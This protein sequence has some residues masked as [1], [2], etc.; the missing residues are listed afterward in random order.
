MLMKG[1]GVPYL[2]PIDYCSFFYHWEVL[3]SYAIFLQDHHPSL[4]SSSS[5]RL[6]QIFWVRWGQNNKIWVRNSKQRCR[7]TIDQPIKKTTIQILYQGWRSTKKLA[8]SDNFL[9]RLQRRGRQLSV[10]LD[11]TKYV[12][13][14][15]SLGSPAEPRPGHPGQLA[16]LPREQQRRERR[17]RCVRRVAGRCAEDAG[18][19][20]AADAAAE[21]GTAPPS[22][23]AAEGEPPTGGRSDPWTEPEREWGEGPSLSGAARKMSVGAALQG[24]G[25]V[26]VWGAT[27]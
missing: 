18:K 1:D 11:L 22:L 9:A 12:T 15:C 10:T 7:T 21:P 25:G 16:G 19:G 14:A 20:G 5:S 24:A 4:F 17:G 3:C 8:E 23:D 6:K 27:K 26:W 2:R 13:A